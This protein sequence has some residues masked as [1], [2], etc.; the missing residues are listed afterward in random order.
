MAVHEPQVTYVEKAV[1][2]TQKNLADQPQHV[3]KMM[4]AMQLHYS[5]LS[6]NVESEENMEDTIY[7]EANEGAATKIE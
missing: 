1:L 7:T 4:Q 6:N 5:W 3:Q 2:Y